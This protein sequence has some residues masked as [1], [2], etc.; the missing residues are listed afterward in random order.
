LWLLT[1]LVVVVGFAGLP[2]DAAGSLTATF[3]KDSDWGTGYQAKYTIA[4]GTTSTVSGWT[5]EFDLPAGTSLGTFWDALLTTAGNHVTAVNRDYNRT[6]APGASVTFGFIVSGSGLPSGCRI[7]GAPCAG[8]G[9]GGGDTSPPTAPANVHVTATTSTSATLAWT[10]STDNVAVTGYEVL[11]GA[12]VVATSTGTSA[13]V[14]GLAPATGF[15]FTVRARDAAGNRSAASAPVT[16]TTQP[17]GGGGPVAL[18]VAPYVDM[19]AFPTPVLTDLAT[20]SRQKGFTLAFITGA[21]CRASWFNA[22][23]PRDGFARDQVDAIRARGGEVKI[24]FGGATGIEL[25]QACTSVDSLVTEY[26]AV[27]DAYALRYIDLD[28]EGSAV[29]EPASIQRRSQALAQLQRNRPGLKVSL[30]LPVLPEGLTADGL[31]VVRSAR[32]AGVDIDLVNVMAMDYGRNGDY[33]DFAV[34]AAQSTFNQLRTLYPARTDAQLW[35]MVGVTPMLGQN[36]DGHIYDQNDARQLVTFA[37]SRHVGVLAFWEVTRDHNAC[38]GALFM[39]T[40][41]PQQPDEFGRIFSAF[42]G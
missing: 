30:T 17:G 27:V 37:Q 10:A 33:G 13:T 18:P 29:A 14:T 38:N 24:S 28:I 35:R 7:N 21:G 41:V 5:V 16:G 20:A 9:G 1:A 8:G 19:G 39:C 40:N 32:D 31:N 26:Q 25:A 15:T 2:A 23:D 11:S 4:N 36:D 3:S 34:Q 42:T 6:V 12:A 22:F